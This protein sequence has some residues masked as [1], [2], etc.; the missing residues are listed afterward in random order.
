MLFNQVMTIDNYNNGNTYYKSQ[1]FTKNHRTY[2]V[3]EQPIL[4][5]SGSVNSK[6]EIPPNG[7]DKKN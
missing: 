7:S 6:M 4:W 5:N 3:T 2:A 1:L